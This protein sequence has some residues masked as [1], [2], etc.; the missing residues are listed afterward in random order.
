MKSTHHR[1]M[2]ILIREC[3]SKRFYKNNGGW[4]EAREKAAAFESCADAAKKIDQ[5][6]LK[7]EILLSFSDSSY[8]FSIGAD[9]SIPR[10]L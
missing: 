3:D 7:A 5:A 6:K 10:R 1:D 4:T 8:D 2:R 9:E